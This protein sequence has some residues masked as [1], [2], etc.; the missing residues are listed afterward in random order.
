MDLNNLDEHIKKSFEESSVEY[1]PTTWD[2]LA[3]R[4]DYENLSDTSSDENID[5]FIR[6]KLSNHQVPVNDSHWEEFNETLDKEESR[7]RR[8]VYIKLAEFA[9][10]LLLILT[11][12]N[13]HNLR[14]G[15]QLE[16]DTVY[17]DELKE[18]ATKLDLIRDQSTE[19]L[20]DL[21]EIQI[22]ETSVQSKAKANGSAIY[23]DPFNEIHSNFFDISELPQSRYKSNLEP[24][25]KVDEEVKRMET[26]HALEALSIKPMVTEAW[27]IGELP[28]AHIV[29]I[30]ESTRENNQ[31]LAIS[32]PVSYDANFINSS[33]NLNKLADGFTGGMD[34]GS[35]GLKASYRKNNIELES[36]LVFSSKT[37]IPGA[38]T[39]Y[40]KTSDKSFLESKLDASVFKQVS[41]PVEV[42]YHLSDNKL[43]FYVTTGAS[44]NTIVHTEYTVRRTIQS[45]LRQSALSTDLLDLKSLPQGLAQGGEF[46]N[47]VYYSVSAG[48]GVQALLSNGI[49]VFFSPVYQ[50]S[51]SGQVNELMK[52][53]NVL[54]IESGL[55]FKF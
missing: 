43:S 54:S 53:I 32:I 18:D 21:A 8:M 35:V 55:K 9:I 17:F 47:N 50:H 48:F 11:F 34:G 19:S 1:D 3:S 4:M 31:G 5:P 46:D 15:S 30:D 23:L 49:S 40:A 13:Y 7:R 41:I 44:F 20:S 28:K 10:F 38:I 51:I 2:K 25:P 42:K 36:G 52:S 37:Y 33:I 12:S 29:N 22:V 45:N 14:S 16:M 6:E 27:K 24:T 39:N 26:N